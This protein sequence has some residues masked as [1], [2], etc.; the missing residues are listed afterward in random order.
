M[1]A[2]D[3]TTI[4]LDL[5]EAII[6]DVKNYSD[7]IHFYF[8][9]KRM[10]HKCPSC[11]SITEKIHDYRTNII[12]DIPIMGKYTFLHYKK[13][14]YRCD[15]CGKRFYESFPQQAKYCR[16]TT[17]LAFYTIDTLRNSQ[18]VSASASAVGV[19]PSYVFRRMK[20]IRF[21]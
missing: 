20:D 6:N 9:M 15:C 2:F 3:F 7:S 13:R 14:R 16:T 4:I 12:K 21:P 19:S 8:S 1:P 18:N 5:E 10:P 11:G 17:R